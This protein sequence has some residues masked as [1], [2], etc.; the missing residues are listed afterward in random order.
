MNPVNRR[1]FLDMIALSELG[2]ALLQVSDHGYDV[3]VGSTA[4]HPIL[5]STYADHPRRVMNFTVN[6]KTIQSTAAG[7]YQLLA[8]YFDHYR[9]LLH[10]NDF[11][12]AAQDEI[13]LQ[14]IRE[15]DALPLIDQGEI[16][17][18]IRQV[19]HLWA[20]MPGAGYGQH[21]HAITDLQAAYLQA[22]GQWA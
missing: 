20:S 19:R 21:E 2:Q 6:G 8:R 9:D 7:R 15:C 5:M 14:Q 22:G 3:I 12:P 16:A 10:L 11:S 17:A 1:A 18:A 4:V 13:A